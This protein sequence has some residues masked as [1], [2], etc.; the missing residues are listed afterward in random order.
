M[1]K[2]NSEL[3]K[4]SSYEKRISYHKALLEKINLIIAEIKKAG[5]EKAIEKIH[6]QRKLHARE[7]IELL[8]DAGTN[9]IIL[10]FSYAFLLLVIRLVIS[11]SESLI[12]PSLT[13]AGLVISLKVIR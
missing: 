5:G 7:R 12:I 11:V 2:P 13:I 3:S 6:S 4:E 1:P 9:F 10:L 8:I